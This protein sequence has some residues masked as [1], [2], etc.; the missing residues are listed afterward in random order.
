MV[1]QSLIAL[2]VLA[3]TIATSVY[4][5]GVDDVF[6]REV[7]HGRYM[8]NAA[9]CKPATED[10][11]GWPAK[12]VT[13][14]IY[15]VQDTVKPYTKKT[16]LVFLAN[17][18]PE[19]IHIWLNAS[20]NRVMPRR[21]EECIKKFVSAISAASGAQFPVSGLVWEDMDRDGIEEGYVFRNGV[22]IRIKE[23]RNGTYPVP[24]L[25]LLRTIAS[26][27]TTVTGMREDRAFARILSTTREDY[28]HFSGRLDVPVGRGDRKSALFWSKIVGDVYR[29]SLNSDENPLIS[30]A[31]CARAGWPKGCSIVP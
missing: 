12:M 16:G 11:L 27:N 26:P 30:A 19:R 25:A 24:N 2:T 6:K 4:G 29:A 15:R 10:V 8:S 23:F 1:R 31:I 28:A 7:E 20:C 17:A 5:Q 18:S 22:T 13:E 3:S 9:D 14:C 21:I